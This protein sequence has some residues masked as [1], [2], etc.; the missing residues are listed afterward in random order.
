MFTACTMLKHVIFVN[1]AKQVDKD[2]FIGCYALESVYFGPDCRIDEDAFGYATPEVLQELPDV[3]AMLAAVKA[4]PMPKPTETPAPAESS[5]VE[6]AAP[7]ENVQATAG[8]AV[9]ADACLGNW[10]VIL[11]GTGAA[12]IQPVQD[13]HLV[14]SLTLNED[15]TYAESYTGTSDGHWNVDSESGALVLEGGG[16]DGY[17]L[18]LRED[19]LL[20]YGEI[21]QGMVFARD[22][23]TI[24]DWQS[25]LN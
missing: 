13:W 22:S 10:Y 2:A 8:E 21:R 18:R 16:M 9:S 7:A 1:G 17:R 19:G 12:V 23:E 15:G 24:L 11:M 5:P 4:D 3:D 6:T 20:Q 14:I 25:E